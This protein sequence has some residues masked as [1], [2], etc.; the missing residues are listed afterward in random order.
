MTA[1]MIGASYSVATGP[2]E[3]AFPNSL[4]TDYSKKVSNLEKTLKVSND[5]AIPEYDSIPAL[6]KFK[7]NSLNCARYVQKAAQKYYGEIDSFPQRDAWNMR[8]ASEIVVQL[9]SK[10]K[11]R[12]IKDLREEGIL[13]P[14][15]ILGL[16]NPKSK[17]RN[18]LDESGK[19]A[20]YTHVVLYV[21][22]D[23]NGNLLF[24]HQWNKKTLRVNTG[25]L[26]E[27]GLRPVEILDP[28]YKSSNV[29]IGAYGYQYDPAP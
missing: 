29:S 3:F 11:Y 16:Y 1:G 23:K 24:D 10:D 27:K 18:T 6:A 9:T 4:E 12:E 15:M 17:Y 7:L 14:G 2:N 25:W 21:G 19:K 26:K 5:F 28:T 8:Y 13:R 22:K 20:K